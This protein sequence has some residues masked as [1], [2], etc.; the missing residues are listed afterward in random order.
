VCD[1]YAFYVNE[2][3][4]GCDRFPGLEHLLPN[5]NAAA[6]DSMPPERRDA[7][8][9]QADPADVL[10]RGPRP[11]LISLRVSTR[12]AHAV[13][14]DESL[15]E[16]VRRGRPRS[17][18]RTGDEGAAVIDQPP[19]AERLPHVPRTMAMTSA[20]EPSWDKP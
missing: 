4:P 5:H 11:A 9:R 16:P 19:A 8:L 1:R 3:T 15:L 14:K 17:V 12:V 10:E 13:S 18:R 2:A 20:K 7:W 6:G